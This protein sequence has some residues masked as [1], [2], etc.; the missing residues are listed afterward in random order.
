MPSE[1]RLSSLAPKETSPA[2][3]PVGAPREAPVNHFQPSRAVHD[4]PL[5]RIEIPIPR[6]ILNIP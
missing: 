1:G 4:P 6:N 2:L 5:H 3:S